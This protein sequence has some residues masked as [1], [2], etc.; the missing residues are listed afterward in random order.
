MLKARR[1][2]AWA[3]ALAAGLGFAAL[4]RPT[5]HLV[6]TALKDRSDRPAPPRGSIDDAS[7]L[8]ETSVKE[9]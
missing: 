7:G 5:L 3:V 4:G 6:L 8:D 1:R 2:F 9:V